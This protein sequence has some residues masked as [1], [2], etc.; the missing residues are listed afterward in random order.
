MNIND[1]FYNFNDD[2]LQY[3]NAWCYIIIGGRNTGKTY[4]TL[5]HT[6]L[7]DIKHCFLKRTIEDVDL[8]CSG[9][10]RVGKKENDFGIDL[11]PYKSINRDMLTDVRAYSIKS[12]IGGFWKH[13]NGEITGTPIGYLLALSAVQKYKGFDLSEC[14]YLIFDE[15]IPQPWERI[16]RKEGEQIMDLYKTVS[17]AREH[18]G[19]E[20]LKL[21]ALAN[22]TSINNPLMNIL[23]IT[24][25][26]AN[27]N[28]LDEEYYYNSERGIL[29][30]RVKI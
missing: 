21:V 16:N 13:V 26:V 2:L 12:G 11:S 8:L 9:S 15:F 10:G 20:P 29:I 23:E 25:I 17:R 1:H 22:A 28:I 18:I 14:D 5:K 24:D 19:K 3:P 7:N 27:M 6:L 4:S 30:H